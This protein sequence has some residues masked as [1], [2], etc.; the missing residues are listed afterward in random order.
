M[1]C[2]L[3]EWGVQTRQK[4]SVALKINAGETSGALTSLCL[5]V[6]QLCK[7]AREVERK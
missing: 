7:P 1:P 3:C 4:V 2:L 6:T 5:N